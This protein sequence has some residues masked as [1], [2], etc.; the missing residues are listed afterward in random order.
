MCANQDFLEG[1][2]IKCWLSVEKGWIKRNKKSPNRP[3]FSGI[4]ISIFYFFGTTNPEYF[5]HL[6]DHKIR[7]ILEG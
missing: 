5:P 3:S 6:E 2:Q 4:Q 1:L 7:L